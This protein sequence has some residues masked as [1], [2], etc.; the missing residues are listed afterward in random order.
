MQREDF[1]SGKRTEGNS[2]IA[3][4]S[5][6]LP[7]REGVVLVGMSSAKYPDHSLAA[8]DFVLSLLALK[9]DVPLLAMHLDS[10]ADQWNLDNV[11]HAT[12]ASPPVRNM[13][14][15]AF[16]IGGIKA[17]IALRAADAAAGEASTRTGVTASQ[18][19]VGDLSQRATRRSRRE[20]P[21]PKTSQPCSA[22]YP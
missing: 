9:H 15:N 7:E 22:R 20:C 2:A 4:R 13:R 14:W 18:L 5:L 6:Q 12:L 21:S 11:P 8:S 10:H 17:V 19:K 16:A 1:P 3:C